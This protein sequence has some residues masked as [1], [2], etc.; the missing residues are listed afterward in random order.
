MRIG[1]VYTRYCR[2]KVWKRGEKSRQQEDMTPRIRLFQHRRRIVP[3]WIVEPKVQHNSRRAIST[4]ATRAATAATSRDVKQKLMKLLFRDDHTELC[5]NGHKRLEYKDLRRFYLKRLHAIH[6]DKINANFSD[7]DTDQVVNQNREENFNPIRS[8]EKL[9]E[10]F[11]ELQNAW[12]RYDE[13]SKSMGK[14]LQ[15]EGAAANFTKF[16]VGCSFSDSEEEKALRREIT[17]QLCRGWISTG[18]VSSGLSTG[19][20]DSFEINQQKNRITEN[21][22]GGYKLKQ[23]S[24]LDDSMF[25]EA[26]HELS[27]QS[28]PN[29]F[30]RQQRTLITRN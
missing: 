27:R 17:D 5:P 4:G 11:Q 26:D 18:L 24:L 28:E 2:G 8:K 6:P 20:D 13:L 16:G 15:G 23:K 29:N 10:D 7:V 30:T 14:V 9:R 19:N 25:V 12:D 1:S 22:T 3:N 21:A